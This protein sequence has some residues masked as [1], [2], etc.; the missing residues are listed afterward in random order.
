TDFAAGGSLVAQAGASA[1]SREAYL[2]AWDPI[3]QRGVWRAPQMD[4]TDAA[5]VL[6]TAGGLVFQGNAAGELV[7]YRDDTGERLWTSLTQAMIVAA[8][9]TFTVDGVQHIAVLAGA[10]ALPTL[11]EG[12]I[13]ATTRASTNNSRRLVY[14]IGGEA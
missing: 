7:A 9:M 13:G 1:P 12:A 5:G 3:N 10:R 8:P 11:G 4:P 6:S 14:R 2:L